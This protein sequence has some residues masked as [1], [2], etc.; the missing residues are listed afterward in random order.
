MDAVILTCPKLTKKTILLGLCVGS[1]LRAL[2]P[3]NLQI[4]HLGSGTG[5]TYKKWANPM[6]ETTGCKWVR[7][8]RDK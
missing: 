4:P 7:I 8:T 1:G 3:K 5:T 2:N 6:L